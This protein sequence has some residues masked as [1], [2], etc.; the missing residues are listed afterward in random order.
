MCTL[1]FERVFEEVTDYTAVGAQVADV[2]GV[3]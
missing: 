1:L 2:I 3:S